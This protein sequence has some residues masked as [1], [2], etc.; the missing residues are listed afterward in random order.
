MFSVDSVISV[1][2][3]N[4]FL[5]RPGKYGL[6]PLFEERL[7]RRERETTYHENGAIYV[8]TPN[9]VLNQD[10]LIGRHVGHVLMQESVSVHIDSVFDYRTCENIIMSGEMTTFSN[11]ELDGSGEDS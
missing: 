11:T 10:D 1:Y 5:W 6:E 3:N 2:E 9:V 4:E 8:T 7:L